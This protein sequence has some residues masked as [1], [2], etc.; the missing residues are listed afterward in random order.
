MEVC[1]QSWFYSSKQWPMSF[2]LKIILCDLID[3]FNL[4]EK[5][6]SVTNWI[7]A[8]LKVQFC[9]KKS[10]LC[11]RLFFQSFGYFNV[12]RR[13]KFEQIVPI[14]CIIYGYFGIKTRTFLE[15][16]FFKTTEKFDFSLHRLL[17]KLYTFEKCLHNLWTN[18]KHIRSKL[19]DFL[20]T[21]KL[22]GQIQ[23]NGHRASCWY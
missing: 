21:A 4:L 3:N 2:G 16:Y 22:R 19:L 15:K 11:S 8:Q 5:S 17:G 14:D 13:F 6:Q 9:T 1:S 7:T 10:K 23:F 18:F 20:L 12:S